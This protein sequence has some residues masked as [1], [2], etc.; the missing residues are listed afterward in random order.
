MYN[1]F[2]NEVEL[3]DK[4]MV[5]Y[6]LSIIE[7]NEYY[8]DKLPF[9]DED[10]KNMLA[11][12]EFLRSKR[13]NKT[14][15]YFDKNILIVEPNKFTWSKEKFIEYGYKKCLISFRKVYLENC[16]KTA[17]ELQ[18]LR[19][20]SRTENN[21]Y[22]KQMNFLKNLSKNLSDLKNQIE[23]LKKVRDKIYNK[24]GD[25]YKIPN[26]K[27]DELILTSDTRMTQGSVG[28]SYI[29]NFAFWSLTGVFYLLDKRKHKYILQGAKQAHDFFDKN[30]QKLKNKAESSKDKYFN[31]IKKEK[32]LNVKINKII[33]DGLKRKEELENTLINLRIEVEFIENF[34]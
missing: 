31:S 24:L 7:K 30:L 5:D 26:S 19:N 27:I 22:E 18:T 6:F 33:D 12:I 10:I 28:I 34:I 3:C 25:K 2:E 32:D 15:I 29:F 20:L 11:E 23:D 1:E 8:V 21:K 17:V 9:L 14:G 16:I 13:N 4:S